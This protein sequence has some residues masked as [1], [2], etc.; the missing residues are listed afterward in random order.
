LSSR[1]VLL[2]ALAI[3]A[4]F[5]GSACGSE[6][7]RPRRG[8]FVDDATPARPKTPATR[9]R[10]AGDLGSLTVVRERQKS[11]HFV[12]SPDV[13]LRVNAHAAAYGK[14]GAA[15][16]EGALI[17]ASHDTPDGVVHFAMEKRVGAE[18][19]NP[20]VP[21]WEYAVIDSTLHT[22]EVGRI[23]TCVRC[24]EEAAADE[25]FGPPGL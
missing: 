15:L 17:V 11:S 20:A 24:H 12:G 5:S 22:V 13:A 18:P 7:R 9:W 21:A 6:E 23:A 2:V 16:G 19:K 3:G 8:T 10:H 1:R 4:L 14:R 25:V